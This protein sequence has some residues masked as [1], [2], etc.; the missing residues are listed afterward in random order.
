M[1][2]ADDDNFND[3]I[4]VYAPQRATAFASHNRVISDFYSC[5]HVSRLT[6][7]TNAYDLGF[8]P[9]APGRD[10]HLRPR[11]R[12]APGQLHLTLTS[13]TNH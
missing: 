10:T 6:R 8:I 2:R 9:S 3:T 12:Y 4:V 5:R 7:L 13:H 11:P 1:S